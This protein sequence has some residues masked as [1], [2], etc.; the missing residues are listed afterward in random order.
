MKQV[1]QKEENYACIVISRKIQEIPAARFRKL[2]QETRGDA[3]KITR[4]FYPLLCVQDAEARI[5]HA[6]RTKQLGFNI[7]DYFRIEF[8]ERIDL[9][10]DEHEHEKED[11]D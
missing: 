4:L 5:K 11:E 2:L 9:P 10:K 6:Q 1:E 7:F 8:A 3:L